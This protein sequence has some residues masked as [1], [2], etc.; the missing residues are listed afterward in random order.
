M[1]GAWRLPGPACLVCWRCVGLERGWRTVLK[2]LGCLSAC[3]RTWHGL[4]LVFALAVS[5]GG[6]AAGSAWA[7]EAQCSNEQLRAEQPFGS[8]LA[9]CRAYEMVSP[10]E[11]SGNG[12]SFLD[13]RASVSGEAV[14]YLAPGSF[15]APKSA[16]LE[17][18]Y[19]A[20][21]GTGG[22]STQNV[23]PPYTDYRS[24]ALYPPPFGQSLFTPDLSSGILES[25]Y[26]PLVSGELVGY[27]NL[28]VASMEAGSFQVVTDVPP[29]KEYKPFAE[30]SFDT[31]PQPEGASTD[32][33]RVVFQQR[34][35]LCCGASPGRGHIYE[36]E[37]GKLSLVD[38]APE[39]TKF[40]AEDDV[41]STAECNEPYVHGD[42]WRAVSADGSRVFFTGG[43][44]EPTAIFGQ[45]YVR[46]NPMSPVEGCAVSGGA[47]TVE[48][49]ASQRS[50]PDPSGP[51]PAF[52][53]GASVS[54]SRVFFTS[55]AELTNDANTG[56]AD[57]AANLYEFDVESGT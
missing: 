49:S 42:P 55:R 57:Q 24:T 18:R 40:E 38:V 22:W 33:S 3:G 29:V 14:T 37:N 4:V 20:R 15:V 26:T 39:G 5:W 51:R 25:R 16:L 30:S 44:G 56:P 28:Y 11:K 52:Y 48:V 17:G 21:R 35:S 54:G 13:S 2:L 32:L 8:A 41:G 31:N 47:C 23:S 1:R 50:V 34:A 12:V 6:L 36:W 7:V 10:L 45:L 53:R 43:E 19:I 27:V 46:E 9:D